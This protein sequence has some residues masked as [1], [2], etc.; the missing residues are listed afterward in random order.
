MRGDEEGSMVGG[1]NGTPR[2]NSGSG[3]VG[4]DVV[5]RISGTPDELRVESY[6]WV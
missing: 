6:E 5:P 2:P 4:S 3:R 1:F